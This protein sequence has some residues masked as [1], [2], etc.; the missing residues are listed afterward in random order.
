MSDL[1]QAHY[2][3]NGGVNNGNIGP[4]GTIWGGGSTLHN[5]PSANTHL[6]HN[7]INDGINDGNDEGVIQRG[8]INYGTNSGVIGQG[9]INYG[10][11]TG[12][13]SH[14]TRYVT[15]APMKSDEQW[16]YIPI[17][18]VVVV[19]LLIALLYAF[20]KSIGLSQR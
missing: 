12:Q 16:A 8:G 13:L 11:N 18:I 1:N 3:M 14:A 15:P 9:G 6:S 7:Y 2:T 10:N 4:S 20:R 19:A 5:P 17:I